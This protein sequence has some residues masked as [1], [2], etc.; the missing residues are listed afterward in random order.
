MRYIF[1]FFVL[2]F[3]TPVFAQAVEPQPTPSQELTSEIAKMSDAEKSKA[4]EKIR[5]GDSPSAARAR[6]WIDIGNGLG[7]GL[8]ATAEKLGVVAN[9]FAKSPVG[10]L[11]MVLIIWNYMGDELL[12]IAVGFPMLFIGGIMYVYQM[13]KTYGTYNEKGK[14]VKYDITSMTDSRCGPAFFMSVVFIIYTIV[15]VAIIT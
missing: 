7:A 8:A 2:M 3:S 12:G 9:D 10:K 13:R 6:E 4:L 5:S 11:A 15:S 1:L 14:F